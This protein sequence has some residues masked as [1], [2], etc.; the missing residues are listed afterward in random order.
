MNKKILIF[1]GPTREPIDPVRYLSNASS[2]K[3]G[4]AIAEKA[5]AS[6]YEVI[7]IT[8]PVEKNNLPR[9]KGI[10]ILSVITAQDMLEEGLKYFPGADAVIFAAA[11]ADYAPRH[12]NAAKTSSGIQNLTLEL[13]AN[14]DIAAT[15]GAMKQIHQK[16]LGFALE[17]EFNPEKIRHKLNKKNLDA[18]LYNTPGSL[19]SDSGEYTLWLR[20]TASPQSWGLLTKAV[21]AEKIFKFLDL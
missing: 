6:G 20:N 10:R 13:K 2:G 7:F 14:P 15:L 9:G 21:V 19:G 12:F 11:V 18:I 17:T 5:L 3:M 1:S 4:K 16:T 8:G